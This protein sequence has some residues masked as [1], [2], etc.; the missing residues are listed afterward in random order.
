M[1]MARF[2]AQQQPNC[3]VYCLGGGG[4]ITALNK[5]KVAVVDE[6]PDYA[7]LA[8]DEIIVWKCWIRRSAF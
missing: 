6:R 4:L 3:R 1:S 7:V 5:N 8:K 2:L